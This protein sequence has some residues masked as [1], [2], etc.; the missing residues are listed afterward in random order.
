MSCIGTAGHVDHGK[1]TLVKRLTGIDPD[2][3]AEEKER[4]MTIDLGFAWLKLPSGREVS[5]VDV[6]GH[7]S[8][9]KNMLAGVGGIDVALVVV[10]ADE[11]VMP[12]TREHLAILDLLGVKWSVV[13]LTKAEL[14]DEEWLEL[15]HS[16]VAEQLAATTLAGS[17]IVPVS[18]HTGQGL[19]TLLAALDRILDQALP[20][21]DIGRP[22][23]SIDRVFSLSGFGTIVTGTLLDGTFTVG[24]EV[25]I[26][27]TGISTR[28]RNLQI[29]KQQVGRA[30]PGSRVAL[31][32]ANVS[33][34]QLKRGDVVVLP[35][36]WSATHLLDAR[37]SLLPDAQLVLTH[38]MRLD[39][40]CGAQEVPARI[41]LLDADELLPGESAWA[42]VRLSHPAVLAR[43]DPFVL[44][45]PS[46]SMT[47]G[48]GTV[49][50]AQ[51]RYHR[52]YQQ[53]ILESLERLEQA[54]PEE[55]IL[56]VLLKQ[57]TAG[58][59]KVLHGALGY[60][61]ASILKLCNLS[62]DVTQQALETLLSERRVRK[63]GVLW[64]AQSVWD[65][66]VENSVHLVSEQHRQ[67]P[68][69]AGLPKEEWR[70]R[71][72]LAPKEAN[73]VLA[74]LQAEGRVEVVTDRGGEEAERRGEPTQ[75]S[76][77]YKRAAMTGSLIRLPAFVPSFTDAQRARI[78]QLLHRFAEH[79][80]TPP[81]RSE[82]ETLVGAEVL[83]ALID[84][85]QFIKLGDGV[86]L[87]RETY[88]EALATV[89]HYLH[90]HDRMTVADARDR[91]GT[92]RKYILP[93]LEH[94]DA[95]RITQRI[96]DVR[97]LRRSRELPER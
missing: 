29:H 42:Q 66:L 36:Q 96:G 56:S 58:G 62:E 27:P 20:P 71:L 31:N 23:L 18:A 39:F 78:E 90:E 3:L 21:Q 43:R 7:E 22:R 34:T 72:H 67:Y 65:T 26:L 48:G 17:P 38:Q 47:L 92:T 32:L 80:L 1:S 9:I 30:R 19:S 60:E 12:Q 70:T 50:E 16:D 52:R 49:V 93:L 84:Q 68:L 59:A 85:G 73:D 44:R 83:A 33:R 91:V 53:A 51:A 41:R 40:Y 14:V 54:A 87:L 24:Q 15:V 37:I 95:L 81:D 4:G 86:L 94:M 10:A 61:I 64:V 97:V 88:E 63:V 76:A 45:L 11:G 74:T 28:I 46:P 69:R 77:W 57:R 6:P 2:R 89:I 13:A 8:F 25:E 5:I 82:A 55:E 35:N 79:P 75:E